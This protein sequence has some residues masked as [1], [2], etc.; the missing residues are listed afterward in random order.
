MVNYIIMDTCDLTLERITDGKKIL[1]TTTTLAN[2]EQT[3]DE[4]NLQAGIGGSTIAVLSSNKQ[5]TLGVTDALW[6]LEGLEV[7]QG[8][9]INPTGTATVIKRAGATVSGA[10][11]TIVNAPATLTEAEV[12]LQDGTYAVV[13]VVA[14]VFT[15]PVNADTSC[16]ELSVIYKTEITGESLEFRASSSSETYRAQLYT[17]AYD[18]QTMQ[19]VK[20]V[21]ITFD[22]VK[23]SGNFTMNFA[24]GT[25]ITPEMSLQ[26]LKP[27]CSDVLG[28]IILEDR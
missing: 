2:L 7:T 19:V 25:A 26:V 11:G 5:I 23:P 21:Y 27:K 3:V 18:P 1:S 10:D 6:S 13:P 28:R 16:P 8:V 14:G 15:V 24:L 17:I 22:Q 12:L 9:R 4:T 20:D